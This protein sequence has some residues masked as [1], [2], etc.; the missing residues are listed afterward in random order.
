[1]LRAQL[2][3]IRGMAIQL[4]KSAWLQRTAQIIQWMSLEINVR[5]TLSSMTFHAIPVKSLFK[6]LAMPV[7]ALSLMMD[8]KSHSGSSD[9]ATKSRLERKQSLLEASKKD[10][11]RQ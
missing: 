8:L 2:I 6:V 7:K 9:H 10:P 1:M 4:A 11:W 3:I 5:L